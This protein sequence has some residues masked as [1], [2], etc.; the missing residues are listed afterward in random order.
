M[1]RQNNDFS[2]IILIKPPN[3][4]GHI[5]IALHVVSD[6]TSEC[7]ISIVDA[8]EVVELNSDDPVF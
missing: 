4:M 1:S 5:N 8:S 3:D 2:R 7:V 6:S